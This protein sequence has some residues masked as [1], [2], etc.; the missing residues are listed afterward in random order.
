MRF[1]SAANEAAAPLKQVGRVIGDLLAF[2]VNLTALVVDVPAGFGQG[3]LA[4]TR[5]LTDEIARLSP[6]LGSIQ[7]RHRAAQD[8][9][10]NKPAQF[11]AFFLICHRVASRLLVMSYPFYCKWGCDMLRIARRP[12]FK[13]SRYL[14]ITEKILWPKTPRASMWIRATI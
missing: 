3:F 5:F 10:G 1:A 14:S 6:G 7:Q 9:A 8:C 12:D 2:V 4:F 11:P 13:P